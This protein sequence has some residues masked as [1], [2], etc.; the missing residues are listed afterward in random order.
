MVQVYETEQL[1]KEI[2]QELGRTL[3]PEVRRAFLQVRRHLFVEQ[4]YQ[5]RGNSLDWDL[6][7]ATMEQVYRD[8][9]LVTQIDRQ[10]RPTSSS[11][12]PSAMAV[13][14][15]ALDVL[16][17]HAVLEIGAGTGYNAAL[18]GMLVG[19]QGS[20]TS[21]DIDPLLVQTAKRNLTAGPTTNVHVLLG[22][23][24]I[25]Y[26]VY[27]PYDRVLAT[28]SV[29]SI[30]HA[31]ID[32]LKQ[33]GILVCN[34]L[35]SLASFFI[36]VEKLENAELGGRLL[37][38]DATYM[39]M[40]TGTLPRKTSTDWQ[41]Y[42]SLPRTDIHLTEN[43]ESLLQNPAYS[44][45]LHSFLPGVTRRYRSTDNDMSLFL[46]TQDT[47][48]QVK[49]EM[50]TIYGSHKHTERQIRQSIDL[51][52]KLHR[53]GI[54]RYRIHIAERRVTLQVAEHVFHLDL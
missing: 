15:E 39:L 53:P 46:L 24:F 38:I 7:P 45:L 52:E 14:L 29:Q 51:Y 27:A 25:G 6:V 17:G 10:G 3:H 1:V 50:L 8:Q 42:D 41:R 32:Q 35:T 5:Q 19:P 28:C 18:L 30:P 33:H 44:L 4:Y 23:G 54:D 47:A 21:I 22:D 40:H 34:L 12:Q 26:E 43:F 36:R 20:V 37:N 11:S 48:I 9:P 2:E 16:D 49:E 13:Q 31:W